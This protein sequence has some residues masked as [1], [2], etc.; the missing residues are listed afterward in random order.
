MTVAQLLVWSGVI[1]QLLNAGIIVEGQIVALLKS[2]HSVM[3]DADLN[4]IAALISAG[5]AAHIA[6]AKKDEAGA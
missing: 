1:P 2:F 3:S 6:L 4:A 5:A